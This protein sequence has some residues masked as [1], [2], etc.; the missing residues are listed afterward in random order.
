M[1]IRGGYNVH[2]AEVEAVLG[3]HPSV[4]AVA[5]VP[6][7][8][9]VMG[10]VGVAVVVPEAG[11]DPPTLEELRAHGATALARHKLPEAVVHVEDL[12]LTSGAK[13]DRARLVQIAAR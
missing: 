7:R 4:A 3:T 2:P 9:E 11:A 6:R 8:D 12:P 5:V 10:E 13:P 1:Y